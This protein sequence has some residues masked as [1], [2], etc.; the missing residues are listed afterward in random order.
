MTIQLL[1]HFAFKIWAATAL[2]V[3]LCFWILSFMEG[4]RGVALPLL[5]LAIVFMVFFVASGWLA[6]QL[7]QRLLPPILHEA[8]VWERNGDSGKAEQSYEKA[9]ALYDSFLTSPAT[10]R[11]EL[12]SLVSRMAR[13]YA[14]QTDRQPAAD[15]FMETYL[16]SYPTDHEIAEHWLH[17]MEYQGGLTPRQQDLASRIGAGHPDNLAIQLILA[18]LY[19]FARRTDFTALQVYRRAM[20]APKSR[21]MTIDLARLFLHEGRSDEWALPVYLWAADQEAPSEALRCGLAACLRW[22]RPSDS[23]A[24][25]LDQA[26][27]ILG[28]LDEDALLRMSSGFV[29]PSG[30]YPVSTIGAAGEEVDIEKTASI[31]GTLRDAANRISLA[32]QSLQ[33]RVA[34]LYQHSPG[35]RQFITWSLIAGLGLGAALF[36]INTVGYLT[37]TPVPEPQPVSPPPAVPPQPMPYTLQV[38]AYLKPEHAERYIETL[39]KKAVAAY[40]VKAH[41]NEKTWY[42]VR[43]DHF[44][45]KAAARAYGISLKQKGIIEDFYVA[46]DQIP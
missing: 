15:R 9:L 6:A 2:S 10:R 27:D 43:I 12:P 39:K 35:V 41:G 38:A 29:P 23:N 46:R 14:A 32:R 1:K 25:F 37:P 45:D 3:P 5:I 18:R 31:M 34:R 36:T 20:A 42:Q 7:A 22:I 16:H 44:P 17:T 13:M 30:S 19:L 21:A 11:R 4:A 40:L 24:V 28:P 33:A 26:R 8:G